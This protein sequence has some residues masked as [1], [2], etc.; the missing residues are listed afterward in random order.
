M[1]RNGGESTILAE[2]YG[3]SSGR[4]VIHLTRSITNRGVPPCEWRDTPDLVPPESEDER[5]ILFPF[6]WFRKQEGHAT[7]PRNTRD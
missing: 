6:I 4:H 5:E 1:E 2:S 3:S 7:D